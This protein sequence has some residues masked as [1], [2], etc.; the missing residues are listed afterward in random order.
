MRTRKVLVWVSS[1]AVLVVVGAFVLL[2]AYLDSRFNPVVSAPVVSPSDV[3]QRLH[4]NLFVADLHSD[5]LLW[6]RDPLVRARRGHTDLPRLVDGNVALQVFSTVTKSPRGQNYETNSGDTDN[7]TPLAVLQLWPASTWRSLTARALY[8]ARRL[9]EASALSNGRLTIIRRAPDLD[10]FVLRRSANGGMVA[11]ILSTEGLHALDGNLQNVDILYQAGF[12]MFG[13]THFFD[14]K[15]AGSAHGVEKGG[16]T[17]FGRQVVSRMEDLHIL[18]DLAHASTRTIQDVLGIAN[19]PVVVSH[20]GV[21][22]TCPGTRNLSDEQLRRIAATGG[23]IGIGYWDG[24][25]CTIGAA[26]TARAIRHAVD[27]VG[28]GHVALGSD[29]DG[30]TRMPFDT[31]GLVQVTQALMDQGFNAEEITRIM[32]GNVLRLLRENLPDK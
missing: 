30:T 23:V 3:A 27:V 19:R 9:E 14:N 4:R 10:Q 16:L 21:Q 8:Q 31:S 22:A 17:P 6:S 1:V 26:S 24:A 25:V 32:G 13:L 7:I 28:V 20:T 18:V 2:P 5:L 11:G 12:R 15:V 29:F